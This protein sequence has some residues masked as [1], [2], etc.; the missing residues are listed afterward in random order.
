[1]NIRRLYLGICLWPEYDQNQD[2]IV[3]KFVRF[4]LLCYPYYSKRI[5]YTDQRR[6]NIQIYVWCAARCSPRHIQRSFG[7]WKQSRARV[8]TWHAPTCTDYSRVI[9]FIQQ[10]INLIWQT[11]V[12]LILVL[13]GIYRINTNSIENILLKN[14]INSASIA[15]RFGNHKSI[16]E[17]LNRSVFSTKILA[18]NQEL[19]QL[20]LIVLER[21]TV[22]TKERGT[23]IIVSN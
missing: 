12:L 18:K 23:F 1:M 2:Q 14:A 10:K 20:I 22:W 3:N 9:H 6:T 17:K 7:N 11:Y 8:Y 19:E 15:F 13:Q 4:V 21:P 5:N 16:I